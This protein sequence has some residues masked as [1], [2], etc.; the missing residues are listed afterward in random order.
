MK[1]KISKKHFDVFLS[2]FIASWIWLPFF[3]LYFIPISPNAA[4]AIM[5][6]FY[7]A[8][9]TVLVLSIISAVQLSTYKKEKE[10]TTLLTLG[11]LNVFFMPITGIITLCKVQ[12]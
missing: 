3:I 5:A 7:I 12:K 2:A 10:G 1:T 11:I 6:I 8:S 9:V 4:I